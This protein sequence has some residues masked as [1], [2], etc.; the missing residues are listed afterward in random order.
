MINI[1]MI[2]KIKPT[3]IG[4][5]IQGCGVLGMPGFALSPKTCASATGG[6]AGRNGDN[7]C[8]FSGNIYKAGS[9]LRPSTPSPYI[10]SSRLH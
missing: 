1:E 6:N 7:G 5:T 8:L 3:I 10:R 2:N 9:S 4:P